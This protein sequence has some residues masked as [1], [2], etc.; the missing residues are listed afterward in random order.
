MSTGYQA[1]EQGEGGREDH[2]MCDLT[3]VDHVLKLT[4]KQIQK[5]ALS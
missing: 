4:F 1:I 2:G 3:T 5:M